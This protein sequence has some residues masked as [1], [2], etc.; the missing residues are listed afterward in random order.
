MFYLNKAHELAPQLA[1]EPSGFL[2]MPDEGF[3]QAFAQ[4]LNSREVALLSAVQRPIAINERHACRWRCSR[5]NPIPPAGHHPRRDDGERFHRCGRRN[6][7]RAESTRS[8]GF[9]VVSPLACPTADSRD[10]QK[11]VDCGNCDI[12]VEVLA[13]LPRVQFAMRGITQANASGR[14]HNSSPGRILVSVN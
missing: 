3:G 5:S 7:P 1:P 14:S 13:P 2:W 9:S 8:L 4:H 12:R 11:R 10:G 6:I